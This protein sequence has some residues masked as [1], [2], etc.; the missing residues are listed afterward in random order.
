MFRKILSTLF[1]CLLV[2]ANNVS[3]RYLQTDPIGLTGGMNTYAYANSNPIN[4]S[5]PTG[6]FFT[7]ETGWDGFNV[8][9]GVAQFSFDVATGNYWGAAVSGVGTAYDIFAS[10]V[11]VLPGGASMAIKACRVGDDAVKAIA[12][13]GNSAQYSVSYETKLSKNM[14]PGRS[15]KAHFQDANKQLYQEMQANPQF[16]Q[17]MERLHPGITKGIQPG[18][19]G[20][21]PRRAPTKD[22]TWHHGVNPGQVQLVPRS[23]HTTPGPVQETLH[24]GGAGGMS[25]WGGGRK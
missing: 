10:A 7:P 23:H 25:L 14:Y 16:S 21:F 9:V 4:Y 11:P 18:A 6:L 24:P 1:L 15:D 20:A 22:V 12:K 5:D 13:R 2:A 19:R 17:M 8:G 3:A